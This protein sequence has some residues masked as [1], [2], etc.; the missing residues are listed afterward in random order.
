M[1]TMVTVRVILRLPRIKLGFV[2]ATAF[3]PVFF[4]IKRVLV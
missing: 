3:R 4:I 1:V 2:G